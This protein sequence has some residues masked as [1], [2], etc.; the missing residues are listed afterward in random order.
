MTRNYMDPHEF[1]TLGYLQEVNRQFL[2]PLGLA[3]EMTLEANHDPF[4]FKARIWDCRTDPEG[5]IF[6]PATIDLA[7]LS[8]VEKEQ[9]DKRGTRFASLGYFIQEI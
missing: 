9:W 6:A 1:R 5:V 7:K 3:L 4:A 8:R 2:H